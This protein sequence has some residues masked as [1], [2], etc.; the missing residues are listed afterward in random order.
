MFIFLTFFNFFLLFLKF[1][2][3][4]FYFFYFFF[5]FFIIFSFFS[6]ILW[7]F[8]HP[9]PT[10]FTPHPTYILKFLPLS[11]H[12]RQEVGADVLYNYWGNYLPLHPHPPPS[13]PNT[14]PP[15]TP[16][17][18]T[19]PMFHNLFQPVSISFNLL[20]YLTQLD[21]M[22]TKTFCDCI[23]HLNRCIFISFYQFNYPKMIRK[24][25]YLSMSLF[26]C[27]YLSPSLTL[28]LSISFSL[29]VSI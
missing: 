19:H 13:L 11:L 6:Y 29:S 16:T 28:S 3:T 24:F 5:Y 7:F 20:K 4:F 21:S 12:H 25:L 14:P 15:P 1:F 2:L 8:H 17:P 23:N 18:H 9:I 26:L 22:V 10:L 27:L